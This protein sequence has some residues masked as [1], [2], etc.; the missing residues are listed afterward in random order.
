MSSDFLSLNE[1][2]RQMQKGRFNTHDVLK[3][4]WG[5]EKSTERW[6]CVCTLTTDINVAATWRTESGRIERRHPPV[7]QPPARMIPWSV[8]FMP[9]MR[10]RF[11]LNSRR[12]WCQTW[13]WQAVG[14]CGKNVMSPYR[15][16]EFYDLER[17]SGYLPLDTTFKNLS[18]FFLFF[19]LLHFDLIKTSI[20]TGQYDVTDW[21]G[22]LSLL[23]MICRVRYFLFFR[24][25]KIDVLV[26]CL[27][28]STVS[29][30]SQKRHPTCCSTEVT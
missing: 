11:P 15:K 25:K 26:H 24:Q 16:Y 21:L 3:P 28:L 20:F 2:Q 5:F 1:A 12:V 6:P 9:E 4:K 13:T 7:L 22:S 8:Y 30:L 14:E 27:T 23:S 29:S 18:F 19:F 10:L 17:R